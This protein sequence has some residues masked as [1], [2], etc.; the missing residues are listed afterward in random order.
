MPLRSDHQSSAPC[1]SHHQSMAWQ[2]AVPITLTPQFLFRRPCLSRPPSS[3][4]VKLMFQASTPN[5]RMPNDLCIFCLG[6]EVASS[7][8]RFAFGKKFL[9]VLVSLADYWPC[10]ITSDRTLCHSHHLHW[11][12]FTIHSVSQFSPSVRLSAPTKKIVHTTLDADFKQS[13]C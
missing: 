8:S 9:I 12:A 10:Y 3:F 13:F 7:T 1:T 11:L 5:A 2:E 6:Q 4:S